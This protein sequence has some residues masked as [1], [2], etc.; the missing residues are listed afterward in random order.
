MMNRIVAKFGGTSMGTAKSISAV[1]DIL[2]KIHAEKIA[3]V[4]ASSGTTDVLIELG[5]AAL[6]H[7]TFLEKFREIRDRHEKIVG[8]LGVSV[9][10]EAMFTEMQKLLQGIHMLGELSLSSKDKLLSFGER[11]SSIILSA[12]LEKRGILSKPIDSFDIIFTDDNFGEANVDF[13]KTN[14]TIEAVINPILSEE[15]LPVVT[16]FLGQSRSGQR[17]TLGRGGS[18]YSGAILAAAMNAD[19]LQIWTD[20]DGIFNADPRNIPKAHP[21]QSLSFEEAGELAYF[22]AKVLH[23]KTIIPAIQ[24]NIPVRILNTFHPEAAG[25]IITHKKIDSIKSVTYKKGISIITICS[26]GML[27]AHGFLAKIFEVFA[28][29]EVIVDV[30]AT[31]EV[32]VSLTVDSSLPDDIL[33]DLAKFSSVDILPNMAIVCLVGNG[34]GTGKGILSRLFSVVSDHVI[35]MVSQGA[36][37]RNVTFLVNESEASEVAKKVFSAFFTKS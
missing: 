20:V 8:D 15:I 33:K 16:G 18:D 21:L 35:R 13:L 12:L 17:S 28:E 31:S 25:T 11:M 26:A 6:Q 30:V 2:Q 24:K 14:S 1:A 9:N 36:S 3:V 32:S 5:N 23:P 22:G 4:S 29:Y 10:F 34:I 19:E 7:G 37:Q 27:N